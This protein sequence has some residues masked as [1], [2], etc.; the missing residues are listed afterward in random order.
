MP[1]YTGPSIVNY[2]GS[3]NQASDFGSR[4]RLA[5]KHGIQGY[6]GS[7]LQNTQ[8]LNTLRG[9]SAQPV[10]PSGLNMS[11]ERPPQPSGVYQSIETNPTRQSIETNP[12]RQSIETNPIRQSVERPVVPQQAGAHTVQSGDTLSAIA[13]RNGMSLSDVLALNP[14]FRTNPNLI[15]PGDV[16]K[17]GNGQQTAPVQE[18]APVAQPI[19]NNAVKTPSG[20]VVNPDTGGVV[21][22]PAQETN[23]PEV[24]NIS[25]PS[26]PEVTAP[27]TPTTPQPGQYSPE[28]Q[29]AIDRVMQGYKLS[30]AEIAAQKQ[31]DKLTESAQLGIT[32]EGQRAVPLE[33]ITGRQKAIEERAQNL[34]LPIQQ[35][36]ALAQ[37]QRIGELQAAEFGLTQEQLKR[38]ELIAASKPGE[39]F[40]LSEGQ[41]RFDS[42]GN[43]IAESAKQQAEDKGFTLGKDQVRY[44]AQGNLIASNIGSDGL[45][46]GFGGNGYVRGTNT[47]VDSWIDLINNG[48]ST[49][50]N[51][52]ADLKNAVAN[53]LTAGGAKTDEAKLDLLENKLGSLKE[54]FN[55]QA[56]SKAVGPNP[57]SRFSAL[58]F[59][60]NVEEFVGAVHQLTSKE[61]LD[62]LVQL[63][64][65]GGTLGALN[66]SELDILKGSA[67][68]LNDW[69]VKDGNGNPTGKWDISEE[70]FKKEVQSIYN[71]TLKAYKRAGGSIDEQKPLSDRIQEAVKE[72]YSAQ[73]IVENLQKDPDGLG[74]NQEITDALKEGYSHDEILKFYNGGFSQDQSTSQKGSTPKIKQ[75]G[76]VSWRHNNPLNIKYGKFAQNYNTSEGQKATDG[77]SFAVFS[78]EAEGLKAARDLLKA[79]SYRN[80]SLE[81]AMRRWSGNG[82]GAD[83]A[84]SLRNKK[85]GEMSDSELNTLINS[86][87]RREGWRAA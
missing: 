81:Q 55:S 47:T 18:Q 58:D 63:K 62:Y 30:P 15:R 75:G 78:S 68:K 79:S 53:G 24:A 59:T 39:G 1:K 14:Q 61:T 16:V 5:K 34:S 38:K 32:E 7:A 70:A 51:V 33:F 45:E 87:K 50:A 43:V 4:S 82:Y 65:Q 12:I 36:A 27:V 13:S 72:G 49:I 40:T 74:Y 10:K 76:S 57:L 3:L 17:L 64:E 71:T 52:P 85:T 19:P 11:M 8:L 83:V 67:T 60:G 48:E 22:T 28:Y 54:I 25:T 66:Q 21:N 20:T 42:Q 69:E 37:A 9:Q 46:G 29:S 6:R 35:R 31:L 2:L 23:S 80:L 41:K 56:L 44:D 73:N 84:P 86:M 77:G 26:I